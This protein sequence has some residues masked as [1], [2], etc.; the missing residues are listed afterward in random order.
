MALNQVLSRD[1]S[2]A[3]PSTKGYGRLQMLGLKIPTHRLTTE[4]P[5]HI[6][7]NA[8]AKLQGSLTTPSNPLPHVDVQ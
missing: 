1:M 5:V 2:H 4:D 7:F 3:M 6:L 8:E